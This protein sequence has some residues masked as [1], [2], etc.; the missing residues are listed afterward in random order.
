MR[1]VALLTLGGLALGAAGWAFLPSAGEAQPHNQFVSGRD[2]QGALRRAELDLRSAR[3]RAEV[4]EGEAQRAGFAADRATRE[5]AALAA[6]IQQAEAGITAAEARLALIQEQ[7]AVLDL[8]LAERRGPLMRLTAALQRLARRPLALSALRSG[9]LTEAVYLRALLAT[10]LPEVERRTR[11]L[12]AEL[13]DSRRLAGEAGQALLDLEQT[14]AQLTGRRQ[15]LATFA[16]N[17]RLASQ[18]A[19][20]AARREGERA[21]ALAEETR[22]LDELVGELDRAGRLRAQ[23]AALPGPILRPPRP[24]AS[25]VM[26]GGMPSPAVAAAGPIR[27]YALPVAGQAVTGFGAAGEAGLR[28]QGITF[29]PRPAAA[30]VAPAP[31]RVAFAGPYRGFGRIVIIEH[32]D[33]WS[34][35]ITGL[36]RT[37]ATVG[38]DLVGGT[39]L[40]YAPT[41]DP[42]ITLELRRDGT[43]VN[44]LEFVE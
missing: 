5:A 14:E 44:P 6:R 40:G 17:Q 42:R 26:A 31:G 24:G 35:V 21:F 9:S 29:A 2:A 11:S 38:Q 28:E 15:Q 4:L 19:A 16:A 34:S 30:V 12:R 18:E 23:L 8:R 32:A 22:S 37:D 36:A 25:Q 39:L 10:T 7:Q 43:P 3:D 1:H 20:N 27:G 13:A 33:G 41:R